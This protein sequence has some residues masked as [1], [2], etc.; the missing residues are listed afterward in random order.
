MLEQSEQCACGLAFEGTGQAYN[1]AAFRHF[2]A[3]ERKR[4]ERSARSFLLVL[5]AVLGEQ[6]KTMGIPPRVAARL[7]SGLENCVREVDFVGWYREATV[8]GAVLTQGPGMAHPETSSRVVERMTTGL[9]KCI[10]V[11]MA[12][13]LQVR[14]L[15][16]KRGRSA[17]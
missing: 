9:R 4:A 15:Q 13:R 2:L 6:G 16:L 5:V 8:M 10:P 3:L 1:E 11:S 7:F 14:A 17:C 12:E